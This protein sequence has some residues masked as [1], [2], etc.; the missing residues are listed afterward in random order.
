[1]AREGLWTARR[2]TGCFALAISALFVALVACATPAAAATTVGNGQ[3]GETVVVITGDVR[4]PT[5]QRVEHVILVDGDLIIDGVA[6]GDAFV[7][8]GDVRVNG[9]VRSDVTSLNGR[10]VLGPDAFVGGDV[11]S[12]DAARIAD[13]A[14]VGGDIDR[15]RDR[16]ALGRLGTVG[17]VFLWIA[18]TISSFL[19]G[20]ILLL[21]TPRGTDAVANAGRTAIGPAIG[22]GFAAAFGIPLV[23]VLLTVTLLGLPLGLALLFALGLIYGSAYALGALIVGRLVVRRPERRWLAFLAGWGALRVLAVVPVLGFLVLFAAV[24]YGLGALVVAV[25]R[26]RRSGDNADRPADAPGATPPAPALA[27]E[28]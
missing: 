12:K 19:L 24:V 8:N 28:A 15:A 20:A 11:V 6:T 25:L 14:H 18:M 3:D 26:A 17:R 1:M 27:P 5:N 23:G 7:V 9:R 21:V 2:L 22:L 13:G 4:V 10:V 16:F